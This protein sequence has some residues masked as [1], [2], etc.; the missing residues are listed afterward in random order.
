MQNNRSGLIEELQKKSRLIRRDII[1]ML[2]EAGS[3][4]CGGCLSSSD[5]VTA[6]YFYH[7]RHKPE[8]PDWPDRDRFI[9]SAL[10]QI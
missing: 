6:L 5:I 3:G 9:L 1:Q 7:L 10:L 4:H 2:Y 8:N